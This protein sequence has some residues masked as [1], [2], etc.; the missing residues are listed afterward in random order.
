MLQYIMPFKLNWYLENYQGPLIN[1]ASVNA[2]NT[3]K[4]ASVAMK[5]PQPLL[6]Y[7]QTCNFIYLVWK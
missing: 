6:S 3:Q 7:N 4:V 2:F 5:S 1:V